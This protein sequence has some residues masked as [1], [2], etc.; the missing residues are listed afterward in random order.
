MR[1]TRAGLNHISPY[2]S[3]CLNPKRAHILIYEYYF[4]WSH[5]LLKLLIPGRT[6][7]VAVMPVFNTLQEIDHV[8]SSHCFLM[9]N[10]SFLTFI[11]ICFQVLT[12]MWLTRTPYASFWDYLLQ[13]GYSLYLFL[14]IM[15]EI[16]VI[17]S[18]P[19]P[20]LSLLMWFILPHLRRF[21]TWF[22]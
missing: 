20:V 15:H 7:H 10:L 17:S 4:F 18:V 14:S 8:K 2:E 11:C 5:S 19:H 9:F 12:S 3:L 22:I 13:Y 1:C 6:V 16:W 21:G